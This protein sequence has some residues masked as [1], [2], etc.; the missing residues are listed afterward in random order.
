MSN[1]RHAQA[2]LLEEN[3]ALRQ[4]VAELEAQLQACAS[5]P[6]IEAA[7]RASEAQLPVAVED[8]TELI[9]RYRPDGTLTFVNE[10]CCRTFG[11]S[12]AELIGQSLLPLIP[13]EDRAL[14]AVQFAA[15]TPAHPTVTY[16]HRVILPSG[17]IRWHR[18]TDRAVY[19][20]AGLLVE[21]QSVGHD[22]T[23]RKQIEQR[24]ADTTAML[25]AAINQSPVPMALLS[26]PDGVQ[27]IVNPAMREFLGVSAEP[28][29]VGWPLARLER[30]WTNLDAQGNVL[31]DDQSP[32]WLALHGIAS[33]N[34]EGAVR[35]KDGTLR[36]DLTS[37]VPI[38]NS[39]GQQIAAFVV[40]MD[41]TARKQAE[42]DLQASEDKF[43]SV[44]EQAGEALVLF[45]ERG[46]CV[47]TNAALERLT[48]VK[49]E[50]W[51]GMT[52]LDVNQR[53]VTPDRRTPEALVRFK[54]IAQTLMTDPTAL[55]PEPSEF[56]ILRPHGETRMVRSTYFPIETA[57]GRLSGAILIDITDRKRAEQALRTA[58]QR[59]Q[60]ILSSLYGGILVMDGQ[61]RVEFAN[62]AFCD[63]FDLN[64]R[65]E[66]LLG[67]SAAEMLKKINRAYADPPAALARIQELLATGQPYRNEEVAMRGD[68][69]YLRDFI[70]IVI[71]EQGYGRLWYH[72][73]ITA[74][75][76]IEQQVRRWNV[77]LEERVLDRTQQLETVNAAL[78]DDIRQRQRIE[79]LLRRS[80]QQY[81]TLF[82]SAGDAIFI[83]TLTGQIVEGNY[84]A[85]QLYGYT[86]VELQQLTL[87]DL[88]TPDQANYIPERLA[89]VQQA[90][91]LRF[92]STHRHRDGTRISVEVN[93]RLIE[94]G[95]QSAILSIVRDITVHK[96]AERALRRFADEQAAL[97]ASA[98]HL[99]P[100]LST[101]EVMHGMLQQV[102]N[103]LT[104]RTAAV[105]LYEPE[106]D[107]LALKLVRDRE[108]GA[109]E[110][111]S[112]A[113]RRLGNDA[114]SQAFRQRRTL[115]LK[116]YQAWEERGTLAYMIGNFVQ[117]LVAVPL[118]GRYSPL[119]ALL[120]AGDEHKP[121]FDEHDVR[122][123]ELF[124]VQ[125]AIALENAQLYE[126]Q[127]EQYQH[128]QDAQA[129]LIQ[130]EKMSAL[131]RLL[132]SISHEIN[133]PLQ[134]I[135][136]CLTLI[137]EGLEDE[138]PQLSG[139]AAD[140][141]LQDLAVASTEVQRIA[142][143][144]QRLRDFYRPTRAAR[145]IVDVTEVIDAV[146]ALAAKQ[147]Q[148]SQIAVLRNYFADQP[149]VTL[150]NTDQ[151]R[152]IVLNLVLNAID[153]M[154]HGG[155]LRVSTTL[156]PASAASAQPMVQIDLSDTGPGMPPEIAARIFEPF[157]TTKDTGSG[158]GLSI[159]YDL[160]RS[161]GGDISVMSEVGTGTTFSI[162]LPV[163]VTHAGGEQ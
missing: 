63:M 124:A 35:R 66:D 22:V 69:T 47:A 57:R 58:F 157:F 87:N 146:L 3:A 2:Q 134:A 104:A 158:L 162:L 161:L 85:C 149:L 8:Q 127:Q 119:G 96:Q 155:Q 7:L 73:D 81:R 123:I 115:I 71:D 23:E 88:N 152:Q 129:R 31:P 93:S 55:F 114:V 64:E 5:Q 26:A 29:W 14:V 41:V 156:K 106:R 153:A 78:Q 19:D 82:E 30:S 138:S 95:G 83:F 46:I 27:H 111:P 139:T 59:F 132:A 28:G 122:L 148:H 141:L 118:I 40:V 61:N 154:P 76:Q 107:V 84:T 9:C 65:P 89:R 121:Q 143:I 20:A 94:Y 98:L 72:Q 10:A 75:K 126:R 44:I 6:S 56:P 105:A 163:N 144:V 17:E 150:T 34:V 145:Q 91:E 102:L 97:Y 133:N 77:E 15:L 136:G 54:A 90:G 109:L 100:E 68:R 45:D 113:V 74:R 60:I 101:V 33:Y 62:Q 38:F 137:R 140:H 80:E 120:I 131:G 99:T 18:R 128:L 67:L 25:E 147:L 53:F 37:A 142:G 21:F 135:Q 160:V 1:V 50:E 130:A 92:E 32:P 36:F 116:D 110:Q 43:R 48:G 13:Q 159:S 16:E 86:F 24:L 117:V 11:K 51:L 108:Q 151:L 112:D 52:L 39:R 49:R 12:R 70:P 4:R 103:L 79:E 125:A 42:A